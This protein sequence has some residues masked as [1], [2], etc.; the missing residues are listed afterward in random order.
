MDSSG[1]PSGF[2]VLPVMCLRGRCARRAWRTS[3]LRSSSRG[4]GNDRASRSWPRASCSAELGEP[5][6]PDLGT[7]ETIV[8]DTFVSELTFRVIWASLHIDF[9]DAY[10]AFL[11]VPGFAAA[12]I[13]PTFFDGMSGYLGLLSLVSA[14]GTFTMTSSSTSYDYWCYLDSGY[15]GVFGAS[16]DGYVDG[17]CS[18]MWSTIGYLHLGVLRQQPSY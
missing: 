15:L 17:C 18:T 8:F 14:L 2:L 4:Y 9:G 1:L 7:V 10:V 13:R 5:S 11:A 3:A 16:E 12:W 6:G